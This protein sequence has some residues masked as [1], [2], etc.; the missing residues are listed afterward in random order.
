MRTPEI[1]HLVISMLT[2]SVD[3]L[4]SVRVTH[5][6]AYPRPP[7]AVELDMS[8]DR[9]REFVEIGLRQ[10]D[11]TDE[12]TSIAGYIEYGHGFIHV[13]AWRRSDDVWFGDDPE[14][15]QGIPIPPPTLRR[16]LYAAL[17]RVAIFAALVFG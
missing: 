17:I 3:R 1:L 13:F 9:I 12:G 15:L 5:R 10:L 8:D 11:W 2:N 6:F 4:E 16:A 14:L 7:E